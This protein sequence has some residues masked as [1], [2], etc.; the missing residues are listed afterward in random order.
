MKLDGRRSS[1]ESLCFQMTANTLKALPPL[2][3]GK[4]EEK[5]QHHGVTAAVPAVSERP[6]DL[7]DPPSPPHDSEASR[8]GQ[9]VNPDTCTG[10]R[11]E[12]PP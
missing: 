3:F 7:D 4:L 1:E 6:T 11:P 10:A 5:G 12:N 8:P 9:R 2:G